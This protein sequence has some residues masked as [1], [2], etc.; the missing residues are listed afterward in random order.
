MIQKDEIENTSHAFAWLPLYRARARHLFFPQLGSR[1]A[2]KQYGLVRNR[3]LLGHDDNNLPF[4][5]RKIGE[6]CISVYLFFIPRLLCLK[7]T[8][9]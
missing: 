3:N 2:I 8:V 9:K 6:K 1:T 4:S 5:T 7:H